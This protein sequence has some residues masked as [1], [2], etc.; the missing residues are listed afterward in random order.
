MQVGRMVFVV[1]YLNPRQLMDGASID[2]IRKILGA[3]R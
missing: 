1:V 3:L 2:L